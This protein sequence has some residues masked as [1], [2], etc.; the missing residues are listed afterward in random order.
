MPPSTQR[1][2]IAV[3]PPAPA[4]TDLAGLVS[5]LAFTRPHPGG[6][7]LRPVPP[8]QWH[9]TVA[10]LGELD[11]TQLGAATVAMSEAVAAAPR[12]PRL[13]LSGG[14]RFDNGRAAAIWAGLQGDLD[15]LHDL[16]ARLRAALTAAR[17]PFDPRPYQ[18]HLTLAR[19]GDRLAPDELSEIMQRLGAY[20]G[21]VWPAPALVLMRSDHPVSNHY[22]EVFSAPLPT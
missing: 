22:T 4:I 2:F 7:S 16:A 1:L 6:L 10:F 19:P 9:V 21:P 11:P 20:A 3:Y 8:E 5:R 17:I 18:P 15:V 14:G 13:R 12:A